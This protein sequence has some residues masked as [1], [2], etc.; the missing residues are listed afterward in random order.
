MYMK[1]IAKKST[2]YYLVDTIANIYQKNVYSFKSMYVDALTWLWF[3][4]YS[5]T[6]IC[7]FSEIYKSIL[8]QFVIN[9]PNNNI[10]Y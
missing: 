5:W 2:F 9:E 7:G 6:L 4:I 1:Y 10:Y 3:Q 8:K